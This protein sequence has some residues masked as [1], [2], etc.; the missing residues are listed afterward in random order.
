MSGRT[1]FYQLIEGYGRIEIPV[2]QRDYAQGRRSQ[3]LIRDDFLKALHDA[4]CLPKDAG[5]LPLDLDFVYGSVVNG[6]FQPLDGQQR[7][8]TLFLL[9]W[10][11][12]WVDGHGENFRANLVSDG[13]SRFGYEV[14]PGSRDFMNALASYEP[15]GVAGDCRDVVSLITDQP[16]Y[17]RSWR[18]DPTIRS[19]LSVLERMHI[20]FGQTTGLYARLVDESAPSITFQLLDLEQFDLSDDLYIKMNARGKPLTSFE[21]F[22]AR[23]EQ[24]LKDEFGDFWHALWSETSVYEF[25]L[26]RIDTHWSDFFWS[27][28]DIRTATFDNAVMNLL[29]FVIM[30]TRDPGS[31]ETAADLADLRTTARVNSYSWFY[32][33]GWLDKEMVVTLI[34]LLERW[35]AGPDELCCYLPDGT[36]IDERARFQDV[37]TQPT[38]LTFQQVVQLAGYVQYLV[39]EQGEIAAASFNDW[40]RVVSNLAINTDYNRPDD[41]RRSFGGLRDLAPGMGEIRRH[42]VGS[43]VDVQGFF[44]YQV[45]EERIKACLL[46]FDEGWPERIDRAEQHSYF[47]GQIGFLL[48]FSGLDLDNPEAE[49]AR[50]DPEAAH[51]HGVHFDHYFSCAERMFMDL[52]DDPRRAGR[53]WERALLA[54]GD[55]LLPNRGSHSL[56][57]LSQDVAWSWKRLLRDAAEAGTSGQVLKDLWDRLKEPSSFERDLMEIIE[58]ESD[59]DPWRGAI[60]ATPT[61]YEYGQHKMIRFWGEGGVYLLKKSQMNG[62]HVELFTYCLHEELIARAEPISFTVG[63]YETAATYD[64]PMLS[65][66]RRFRKSDV[67]FYLQFDEESS[68]QYILWLGD[69]KKPLGKLRTVL[70]DEGLAELAFEKMDGWWTSVVDRDQIKRA[71][72]ILDAALAR[73]A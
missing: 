20:I 50:L 28:R 47:R 3:R 53:L 49:L 46:E 33:K 66:S 11:L 6:S 52:A 42:L 40:I 23:F 27:F 13:R 37:I 12:A 58:S 8:T 2:I 29:R 65:L 44:R 68:G 70:K 9:H 73:R 59:L 35:S 57:V 61:A 60:V 7:L 38:N 62:A 43:G 32:E 34:T 31:A 64:Q 22:K 1:T 21:T 48:R 63:Y 67:T 56:L 45:A 55:F 26:S 15:D 10:Y 25:F 24:H 69:P 72:E 18:L 19:A 54:V 71:V 36:Y 4:L 5:E 39:Q 14:R 16:W 30:V 51:T 17:Y 41:L